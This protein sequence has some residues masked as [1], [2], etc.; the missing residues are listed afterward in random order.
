MSEPW[1]KNGL[2]FKCTGCGECCTGAPGFVWISDEEIKA[3]AKRLEITEE[4]FI[5]KYTH[6]LGGRRSL[7]EDP[8]TYD[9]VFLKEKRCEIYHDRPKQCRTFPWWP[10]NLKSKRTWE[11]TG[12][13]CEGVNHPEA[14][15]ISLEEINKGL[16]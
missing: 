5:K 7:I 3:I 12:E 13:R 16:D 14:P 4:A 2:R 1:Y 15:L 10:E 9:C 11:E 6:V 8:R